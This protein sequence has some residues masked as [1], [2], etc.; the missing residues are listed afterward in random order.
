MAKNVLETE[1]G[2]SSSI[3]TYDNKEL[4][5]GSFKDSDNF[6]KVCLHKFNF[7]LEYDTAYTQAFNYDFKCGNLPIV[8][9]TIGIDDC[10]IWTGLPGEIEYQQG[11]KLVIYPSPAEN[12]ITIKLPEATVDEHKWGP[13]T[14]RQYNYRYHEN[15]VL[16]I[17]DI[18]GRLIEEISLR[19]KEGNELIR[20]VRGY[21][22]GI[23]LIDLFE[24]QKLMA[25]GKFVKK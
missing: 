5:T 3:K 17:F 21:K 25:S 2:L 13:M 10:D 19:D 23:Y 18:F 16:K 12:E 9:D 7:D 20:A 15:S 14:S 11:Q 6:Y 1:S 8:T 4:F 24:N 22:S